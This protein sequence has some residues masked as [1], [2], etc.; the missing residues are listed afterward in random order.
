MKKIIMTCLIMMFSTALIGCEDNVD[1]VT[2]KSNEYEEDGSCLPLECE[3]GYEAKDGTCQFIV[4]ENHVLVPNFIGGAASNALQWGFANGVTVSLNSEFNDDV[5]KDQVYSQSVAE[6]E[7]VLKGESISVIYSRGFSPDGEITVPDFTGMTKEEIKAWAN[8]NQI[9][10]VHFYSSYDESA[11]GNYLGYDV[12]KVD[13]HEG[14]LRRDRYLFYFSAG[15][16]QIEELRMDD[17]S[18]IRGVNLG[19]WFVLEGWMT[20]D[21]F[22]G[23]DGSDET[24][25]MEQKPN[26]EEA[27]KE[28]WETFIT[29]DDFLWLQE[30][31]VEYIR[32]PIPWWYEG[33]STVVD[34]R[35]VVYADSSDYIHKAMQWAE[36]YDLKVLLDLHTAPGCQNGF[37]NGGIAGQIGWDTPENRALTVQVL[38]KITVEFSKYTS[39]WGIEVLNEPVGWGL[40]M[41][42]LIQFYKDAYTKIRFHNQNVQI[43]FHDAFTG[44]DY[45]L[46]RDFFTENDFRNVFFDMHL[47]QVFGDMWGDFDIH[48]HLEWVAVEQD[49]AVHRFDGIV[50]VVIGEWSIG[51]QGNVYEG[52]SSE[53]IKMLKIAFANA[54]IN[55]Y[56][57]GMGWFFWN[58]KIDASSHLEWDFKRLVEAEIFP[59]YFSVE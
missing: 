19:G 46:W 50:P 4:T 49:K 42:N 52:L 56:D 3:E 23:V 27:L 29:E 59:N 6:G 7:Y 54:Q 15:P 58:Y 5:P 44:W 53:S 57:E 55:K 37:D 28:H 48:D 25:F 17:P 39:L 22:S 24:V 26:A 12:K 10:A 43:G 31:G 40:N 16:I 14:N 18:K 34:G 38:E 33:D 47:Y 41:D 2:C 1:E 32:L 13:E 20:P 9:S 35:T 36:K 45:Y 8:S 30:H 21:L 11:V 51:L